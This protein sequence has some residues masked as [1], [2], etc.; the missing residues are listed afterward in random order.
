V[1][2]VHD[3]VKETIRAHL[4]LVHVCHT[5]ASV[6]IPWVAYALCHCTSIRYGRIASISAAHDATKFGDSICPVCVSTFKCLFIR[7]QP[8]R[9]L[10]NTSRGYNLGA[11]NFRSDHSPFFISSILPFL[12]IAHLVSNYAN[13]SIIL[14]NHIGPPSKERALSRVDS[15]HSTSTVAYTTKLSVLSL[16]FVHRGKQSVLVRV[17]LVQLG[18]HPTPILKCTILA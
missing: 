2:I 13:I 15:N 1:A 7:T 9:A 5:F 12:L 4:T 16:S 17:F 8:T 18:F 10:T 11:S 14:L 6:D 3:V